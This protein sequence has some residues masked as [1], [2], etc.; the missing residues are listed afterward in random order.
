MAPFVGI[1][2]DKWELFFFKYQ[3]FSILK[4]IYSFTSLSLYSQ[5][6]YLFLYTSRFTLYSLTDF[7]FKLRNRKTSFCFVLFYCF[8]SFCHLK[9]KF[10]LCTTRF[11]TWSKMCELWQFDLQNSSLTKTLQSPFWQTVVFDMQ[12]LIISIRKCIGD[13]SEELTRN[14]ML[15]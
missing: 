3:R 4:I 9:T 2:M 11:A 15:I 10:C 12:G 1:V 6:I 7:F 8:G 14:I 13:R 5:N